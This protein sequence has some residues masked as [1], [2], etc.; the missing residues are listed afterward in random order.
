M[1]RMRYLSVG[2]I[3]DLILGSIAVFEIFGGQGRAAQ[4]ISFLVLNQ[5]GETTICIYVPT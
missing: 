3:A 4:Y 5:I 2:V 1:Y